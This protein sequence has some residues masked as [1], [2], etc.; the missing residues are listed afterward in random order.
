RTHAF[1][2]GGATPVRRGSYRPGICAE[3]ARKNFASVALAGELAHVPFAAFAHL[4][5]AHIAE[6]RVVRPKND[7]ASC[8]VKVTDERW[9]GRD[10]VLVGHGTGSVVGEKH[11]GVIA[12][13][14][15]SAPR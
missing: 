2:L 13:G 8:A 14:T 1:A 11:R 6:M 10:H 5:R 7:F 9:Q 15:P 4:G 3:P 12:V